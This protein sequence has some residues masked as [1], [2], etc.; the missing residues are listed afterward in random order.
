MA[1]KRNLFF[2]ALNL[3]LCSGPAD[4]PTCPTLLEIEKPDKE[5]VDCE[6][7][8]LEDLTLSDQP[9]NTNVLVEESPQYSASLLD[10]AN[11]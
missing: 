7:P 11:Q 1:P 8:P 3:L 5:F 10:G 6:P 2:S 9:G 4:Q